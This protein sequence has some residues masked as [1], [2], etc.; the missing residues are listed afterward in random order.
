[1]DAC[2]VSYLK[3]EIDASFSCLMLWMSVK[4]G[5]PFQP[6]FGMSKNG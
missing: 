1:L 5:C 3:A 6:I 4:K 2:A